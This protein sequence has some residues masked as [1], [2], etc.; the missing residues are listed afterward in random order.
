MKIEK[1]KY[2]INGSSDVIVKA[3]KST[4]SDS[5]TG[6]CV[7]STNIYYDVDDKLDSWNSDYFKL[8]HYIEPSNELFPMF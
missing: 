6:I 7:K 3:T 2:Y 4:N 5:F 8:T 1:G